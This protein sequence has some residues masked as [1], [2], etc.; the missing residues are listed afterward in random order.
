LGIISYAAYLF[1]PLINLA[2]LAN[3]L[4][5][6]IHPRRSLTMLAD[7]AATIVLASASWR[8]LEQPVRRWLVAQSEQRDRSVAGVMDKG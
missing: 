8:V 7:L 3:Y 6:Q 5:Y 2:E 1:H 4:G